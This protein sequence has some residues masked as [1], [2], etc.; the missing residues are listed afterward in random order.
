MKI[1]ILKNITL[2]AEPLLRVC[3]GKVKSKCGMY[4]KIKIRDLEI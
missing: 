4:K 2:Q 3:G 1:K